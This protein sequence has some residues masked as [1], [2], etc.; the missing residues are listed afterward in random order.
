MSAKYD[1]L[2]SDFERLQIEKSKLEHKNSEL[3]QLQNDFQARIRDSESNV[4]QYGKDVK[5]LQQDLNYTREQLALKDTDLR[6]TLNSLNENQ[7]LASEEKSSLWAELR[8]TY[9]TKFSIAM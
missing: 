4:I 1:R 2:E 7:R 9:T 8:F 3:E 6:C 5:T